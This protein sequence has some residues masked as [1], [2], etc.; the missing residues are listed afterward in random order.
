LQ[1]RPGWM[2]GDPEGIQ[3]GSSIVPMRCEGALQIQH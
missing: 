2:G 1:P 3:I